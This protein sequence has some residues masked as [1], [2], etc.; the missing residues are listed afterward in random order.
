[1]TE[2]E[3]KQAAW[4]RMSPEAKSMVLNIDPNFTPDKLPTPVIT[5]YDFLIR[6]DINKFAE[7]IYVISDDVCKYCLYRHTD[8]C[9][10]GRCIGGIIEYLKKPHEKT[11]FSFL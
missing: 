10:D 8:K 1:M 7:F 9:D 4:D 2:H 5:N 11:D 3:R 6:L